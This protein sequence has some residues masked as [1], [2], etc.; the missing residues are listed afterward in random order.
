MID[1]RGAFNAVRP[2]A[3][4]KALR[5][6]GFLVEV[7]HWTRSFITD[8]KLKIRRGK[9]KEETLDLDSRLS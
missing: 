3:M 6:C 8:R 1:V 5:E 7:E 9:D 4:C 2:E